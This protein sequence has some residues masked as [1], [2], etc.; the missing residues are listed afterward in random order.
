MRTWE[1]GP[2]EGNTQIT[3]DDEGSSSA[4][5]LFPRRSAASRA[6]SQGVG[7]WLLNKAAPSIVY[8]KCNPGEVLM[9][10]YI[11]ATLFVMGI[12]GSSNFM[13]AITS[14]PPVG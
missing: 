6:E 4:W 9:S 10:R 7:S 11:L 14:L 13:N 12:L 5:R 1:A 2:R 8:R 3:D